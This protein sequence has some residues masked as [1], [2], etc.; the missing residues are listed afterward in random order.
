MPHG[1]GAKA[2]G[3]F[4]SMTVSLL[5]GPLM[6]PEL[7]A[8]RFPSVRSDLCAL[9]NCCLNCVFCRSFRVSAARSAS[10]TGARQA[11]VARTAKFFCAT[12]LPYR[13]P[14]LPVYRPLILQL[15]CSLELPLMCSSLGRQTK[16]I[17]T[18]EAPRSLQAS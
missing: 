17:P 15:P 11:R 10:S 16:T 18:F 2:T 7:V 8:R 5:H 6:H 4:L 3:T 1:P 14:V 12:F 9:I 13:R